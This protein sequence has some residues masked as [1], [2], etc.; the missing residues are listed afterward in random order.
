MGCELLGVQQFGSELG[1]GVVAHINCDSSAVKGM[2]F[3]KGCGKV[4][5]IEVKQLWLQEKVRSGAIGYE[6]VPRSR[7]PGD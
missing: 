5:H 1:Y 3:R 7:H 6:K 2:L 4:K